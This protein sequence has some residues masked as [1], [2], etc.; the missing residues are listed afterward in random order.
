M[1]ENT[2]PDMTRLDLRLRVSEIIDTHIYLDAGGWNINR[3]SLR[4]T[5]EEIYALYASA[6]ARLQREV[7]ESDAALVDAKRAGSRYFTAW[8]EALQA[9]SR[10]N[11]RAEVAERERDE[12]HEEIK[13]LME[14]MELAWGIIANVSGGTWD[15]QGPEWKTAAFRWREVHWHPALS[16]H[17]TLATP[18]APH[19]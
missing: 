18:E 9:A 19:A 5:S 6:L 13:R 3:A 10:E 1:S 16:R 17:S 15:F 12:A 14:G 7:D 8:Q 4:R 11:D 2:H